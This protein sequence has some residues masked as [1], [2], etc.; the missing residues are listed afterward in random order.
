M[1]CD[2]P[3][4]CKF[5]FLDSCHKRFLW[6]RKEVDLAPHPVVSFAFQV[7]DALKFPQELGFESLDLFSFFRVGKK[8]PC[9][10]AIEK[11]IGKKETCTT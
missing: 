4:P 2:I 6:T 7:G 9:F 8:G 1:A 11:D 5:P 3:E 10:T